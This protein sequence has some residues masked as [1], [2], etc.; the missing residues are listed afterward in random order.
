MSIQFVSLAI[1]AAVGSAFL[2]GMILPARRAP[3]ELQRP[4]YQRRCAVQ[5]QRGAVVS[6]ANIPLHRVALYDNFMV[7]AGMHPQV[8]KYQELKLERSDA[9]L[10][11]EVTIADSDGVRIRIQCFDKG[12]LARLLAERF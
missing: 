6:G 1:V 3:E 12:E 9:S 4:I 2:I 8:L 10:G 11:S 5:R 7:V